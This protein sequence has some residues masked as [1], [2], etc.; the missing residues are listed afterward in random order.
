MGGVLPSVSAE[1]TSQKM[2]SE[3]GGANRTPAFVSA[4]TDNSLFRSIRLIT[5]QGDKGW[6]QQPSVGR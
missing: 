4:E 1:P 6:C 3:S 2:Q 5:S